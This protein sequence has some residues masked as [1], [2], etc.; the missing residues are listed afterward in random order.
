MLTKKPKLFVVSW[1]QENRDEDLFFYS[2]TKKA[3]DR[4]VEAAMK[5]IAH[6]DRDPGED[7]RENYILVHEEVPFTAL[8]ITKIGR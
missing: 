3:D 5:R 4:F 2:A 1:R 8:P 6:G 7:A